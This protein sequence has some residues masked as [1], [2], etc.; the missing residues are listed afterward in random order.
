MGIQS[1]PKDHQARSPIMLLTKKQPTQESD[2]VS[3]AFQKLTIPNNRG[4][5][6]KGKF[7]RF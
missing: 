5:N 7:S 6:A 2:Y 1:L 3:R 4:V